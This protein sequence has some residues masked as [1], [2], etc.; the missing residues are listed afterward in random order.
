MLD[1]FFALSLGFISSA[2]FADTIQLNPGQSVVIGTSDVQCLERSSSI[3]SL[4]C[5]N[6]SGG[7]LSSLNQSGISQTLQLHLPKCELQAETIRKYRRVNQPEFV[8]ICESSDDLA[9]STLVLNPSGS[10]MIAQRQRMSNDL[11]CLAQA[12]VDNGVPLKKWE[13]HASGTCSADKC[14]FSH[15]L[16]DF[17]IGPVA[18]PMQNSQ[19][20]RYCNDLIWDGRDDWEMP[21]Y[22]ELKLI[23]KIHL[24]YNDEN[25]SQFLPSANQYFWD[26]YGMSFP[27]Q[28]VNLATG[29]YNDGWSSGVSLKLVCIAPK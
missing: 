10:M 4:D 5:R 22:S 14:T 9:L 26:Y 17:V 20:D 23:A 15:P 6:N 25:F 11:Q 29:Q 16:L 28:A 7:I 1:K 13:S 3:L 27:Y 18:G 8:S 12:A 24:N 21:N 2:A 19:A